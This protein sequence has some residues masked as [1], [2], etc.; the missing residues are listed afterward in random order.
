MA[1]S[2]KPELGRDR[3]RYF[4]SPIRSLDACRSSHLVAA[5]EGG[6]GSI[7]QIVIGQLSF[8]R[9]DL[10]RLRVWTNPFLLWKLA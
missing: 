4:D 6:F 1:G 7:R 9:F 10:I 5:R 3:R 8:C 2:R